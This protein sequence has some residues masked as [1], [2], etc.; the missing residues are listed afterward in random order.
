[1]DTVI[2]IGTA[3]ETVAEAGVQLSNLIEAG[4][5]ANFDGKTY[6]AM[7]N[8]FRQSISVNGA[9]VSDCIIYGGE[10]I[11]KDLSPPKKEIKTV[12]CDFD[13]QQTGP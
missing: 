8:A 12:V 2:S 13:P 9:T 1:M 10:A 7:F 6:R 4:S 11:P 3:K 5:K